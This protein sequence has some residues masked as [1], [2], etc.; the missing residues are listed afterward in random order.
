M[1]SRNYSGAVDEDF[2]AIALRE[3]AARIAEAIG[4]VGDVEEELVASAF[5]SATTISVPRARRRLFSK[6]TWSAKARGFIEE[7]TPDS[8]VFRRTNAPLAENEDFGMETFGS[9]CEIVEL[10]DP[11]RTS[12]FKELADSVCEILVDR[13]CRDRR[14]VRTTVGSAIWATGRRAK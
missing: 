14:L 12:S 7:S 5:A 10:V 3:L 11:E 4:T 1:K 2:D 13:G 9:I 8:G 6:F